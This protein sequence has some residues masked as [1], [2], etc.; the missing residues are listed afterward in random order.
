MSFLDRFFKGKQSEAAPAPMQGRP[1]TRSSQPYGY[2]D[3]STV[4]SADHIAAN[5]SVPIVLESLAGISSLCFHGFDH[6][7]KPID[8]SDD[9]QGKNIEKA[10]AQI[11]LQE[12]RIGRVGKARK[13][14]TIGLVRAVAL[15]GWSFRQALAEHSTIQEGNWLNFEEIQLLPAQSFGTAP[16]L[17]GNDYLSDV[18][19]PGIVYDATQDSTRFFQNPGS[20]GASIGRAM[21]ID[22]ENILYI[23]DATVP[24][25]LSFLK[26]L[27][28]IVESW[29]EVRHY[30]MTAE[31]RVAVP[32]ETERIDANDIV[33]MIAAKIP[34]K[35]QDL[36]DHCDDLAENQSSATKKVAL[37]GTRI[38][39]PSISMPLNPWE[40]DQ[41]LKDE[42]C[43]FFFK[44]NVIKRVEQAVSSSDNAAKALLDIHIASERELWGKPFEAEIWNPWL[45]WNGFELVDEFN[46]WS[47]TPADQKAEHQKNLE[48]FRSHSITINEYRK[49]EGMDELTDGTNGTENEIQKLADEHALIFG[50]KSNVLNPANTTV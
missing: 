28:P 45:E 32:N 6:E 29:K 21:E 36:V 49:L 38:E 46:W 1:V 12:K 27:N 47:W 43:D 37:A 33:K 13:L 31:R 41:Y 48:N 22:P 10:L 23:E 40:A 50:N 16:T 44:R 2:V 39:Y 15:D 20:I 25:D 42:V 3:R 4:V 35:M 8:P 7:L 30:G 24:S 26:V 14:G 18:I 9:T 11:R 17:S 19:L 5:R 34:V